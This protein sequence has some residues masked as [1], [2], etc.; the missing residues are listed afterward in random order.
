MRVL[1]VDLGERRIGLALSDSAGVL[2]SPYG[3]ITRTGVE[4]DDLAALVRA[5]E[6]SG[7][8]R[9]VIG[10]PLHLSGA[11][12]TKAAEARE[13]ARALAS[14]VGVGVETF[15]ERLT[16]VEAARRR[17]ERA[18]AGAGR[19]RVRVARGREGIDAEAAA[20]LL[21]AYLQGRPAGAS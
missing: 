9:V 7:A 11:A 4:A 8:G 12:G 6:E 15:D 2:A 21:E 14:V 19:S 10:L 3:V 17:R 13:W 16:T 20:V 1:A 18:V 5:V